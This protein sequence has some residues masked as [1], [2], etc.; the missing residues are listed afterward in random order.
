MPPVL[1]RPLS[2]DWILGGRLEPNP[3]ARDQLLEPAPKFVRDLE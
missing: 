2:E 1:E 3:P